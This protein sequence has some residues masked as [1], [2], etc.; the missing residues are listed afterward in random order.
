MKQF[1][2]QTQNE[3]ISIKYVAE[4]VEYY[5]I[6]SK[7]FTV[8]PGQFLIVNHNVDVEIFIESSTNV[9]GLCLF[10]DPKWL[11]Q[12]NYE[13]NTSVTNL[14][15][16][17]A[18]D[19]KA[20]AFDCREQIYSIYYSPLKSLVLDLVDQQEHM[21]YIRLEAHW[22][23]QLSQKILEQERG[24]EQQINLI[25]AERPATR[26]ELY[27]RIELA[28][29]YIHAHFGEKLKV[30]EIAKVAM[31]SEFHFLRTFK[32]AI[33]IS[34]IKYIQKLRMEHAKL[35]LESGKWTITEIAETCGYMDLQ[36]FSKSFKRNYGIAP[37]DV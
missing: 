35:L 28:L 29:E 12:M 1:D 2:L 7:L 37:S 36:Y 19:R 16:N 31:L 20:P 22:F 5:R 23:Y 24:I 18:P 14:L 30:A 4:G 11:H 27:K 17:P 13:A 3:G 6:G 26:E 9:K 34:P 21:K 33:G 32:Q 15:E 10:V 8:K 25:N